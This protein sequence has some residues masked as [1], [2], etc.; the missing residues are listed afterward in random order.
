[1]K[2]V[3]KHSLTQ[4]LKR[5]MGDS[6][7]SSDEEKDAENEKKLLRKRKINDIEEGSEDGETTLKGERTDD[8]SILSITRTADPGTTGLT[9][10]DSHAEG[11]LAPSGTDSRPKGRKTSQLSR[12]AAGMASISNLE[13]SMCCGSHAFSCVSNTFNQ[14]MPADAVLAKAGAEEVKHLI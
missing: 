13:Q 10:A 1:M 8:S 6:S 3:A 14:A 2:K 7:D 4:R 11:E 12:A 5:V 9:A